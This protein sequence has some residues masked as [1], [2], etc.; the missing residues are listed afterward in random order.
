MDLTEFNKRRLHLHIRVGVLM[1][2]S[3]E[4]DIAGVL[5]GDILI[6][7]YIPFGD[8]TKLIS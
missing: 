2:I 4:L 5:R 7:L 8:L 6:N 3:T 1:G